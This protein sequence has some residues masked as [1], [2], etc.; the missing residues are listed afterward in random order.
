MAVRAQ[1]VSCVDLFCG[2]GGLTK[3]LRNGGIRVAAGVDLDPACKYPYEANNRAKFLEL[4]VQA[5]TGEQLRRLFPEKGLRLLAGCAPCQPFSTY[6]QG[7]DTSTDSKWGLLKSF[8][9]LVVECQ[10][11][12]VTMENVP[13]LPRHAVFQEFLE[14]FKGYHVWYGV[15]DC[16]QYGI[17]Q[18]RKRLVLLASRLGPIELI[19]PTHN[20]DNYVTVKAVIGNLPRLKSGGVDP[21]DPMHIASRLSP[22]NM[23]R[24]KQSKPG[25][26]WRDWDDHLVAECHKKDSGHTYSGV[27]GRME[28]NKVAPTMTTLCYG[29]G[30]GRFGHPT[31]DRGISLREAAMF[32]TFP[33]DYKFVAPGEKIE[34][35]KIGRLIGN[36]VPVRLGEI[37][38]MSVKEHLKAMSKRSSAEHS[39]RMGAQRAMR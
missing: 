14:A 23:E 15:V 3:G 31:Q 10:P 29:F 28:W 1:S 2:A 24:I 20:V 9:R 11:D 19:A 18:R 25:G 39:S 36:A 33:R 8:A 26:T 22:L 16:R 7:R 17:P 13:Q 30:N 12:L 5:L 32:Q 35:R 34:F 6:S 21:N 27:Y 37:I 4:D 38:A